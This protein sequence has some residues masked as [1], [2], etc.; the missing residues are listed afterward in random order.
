[1]PLPVGCPS[2]RVDGTPKLGDG[3]ASDRG[4]HLD[5]DQELGERSCSL[6]GV[7]FADPRRPPVVGKVKDREQEAPDPRSQAIDTLPE[8]A[9]DRQLVHGGNRT[10]V[11]T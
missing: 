8:T 3:Q 6:V 4:F 9:L 2:G 7:E 11:F 10:P 1:M 5:V